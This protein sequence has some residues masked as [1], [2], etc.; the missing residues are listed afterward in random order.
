MAKIF[1]QTN[2]PV[3]AAFLGIGG[4]DHWM[5]LE[6]TRAN[7]TEPAIEAGSFADRV[8]DLQ[9]NIF[10]PAIWEGMDLLEGIPWQ[11]TE[12]KKDDD[13]SKDLQL[14]GVQLIRTGSGLRPGYQG[15]R[16]SSGENASVDMLGATTNVNDLSQ[17]IVEFNFPAWFATVD[18]VAPPGFS[19]TNP[20]I[21]AIAWD[22]SILDS[23]SGPLELPKETWKVRALIDGSTARPRLELKNTGFT[24]A[25]VYTGHTVPDCSP[26][27]GKPPWKTLPDPNIPPEWDN[28]EDVLFDETNSAP[29]FE[30]RDDLEWATESLEN[31]APVWEN[32]EQVE[33]EFEEATTTTFGSTSKI[34]TANGGFSS[35]DYPSLGNYTVHLDDKA[36]GELAVD[37]GSG[38]VFLSHEDGIFRYDLQGG[39]ETHIYSNIGIKTVGLAVD[40][41]TKTLYASHENTNGIWQLAYDGSNYQEVGS[42]ARSNMALEVSGIANDSTIFALAVD[43]NKLFKYNL[44]GSGETELWND[45]DLVRFVDIHIASETAYIEIRS[46]TRVDYKRINFDGTDAGDALTV[47]VSS[48]S[49]PNPSITVLQKEEKVLFTQNAEGG[50]ASVNRYDLDLTNRTSIGPIGSA[51]TGI[52]AVAQS[53]LNIS[54]NTGPEFEQR[55]DLEYTA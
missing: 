12:A 41:A 14:N 8:L 51:D 52:Y 5:W 20:E 10:Y 42:V 7:I 46:G 24:N 36:Y 11:G 33:W 32:R 47:Q 13:L 35:F 45:A 53:K 37:P 3:K 44:D 54:G 34:W 50:F 9:S 1:Q 16:W 30:N 40:Q 15:P 31:N 48:G 25:R 43:D 22:G 18:L 23:G 49:P 39:N 55:D 27:S 2:C 21:Q 38:Y 29:T 17:A 28:R 4:T 19:L 26:P 6:P